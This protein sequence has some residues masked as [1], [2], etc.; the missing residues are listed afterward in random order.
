[1][2]HEFEKHIQLQLTICDQLEQIADTLPHNL[3]NQA[4]LNIARSV[5]TTIKNA[6]KFEEDKLFP[7]LLEN[8]PSNQTC[9]SLE[10]LCSEHWEDEI[11]A[12][13]VQDALINFVTTP[14]EA[15]PEALGY[16]LRGFF[17]GVRRHIA[18]EREQILPIVKSTQEQIGKLQ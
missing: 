6:H 13:D 14:D 4:C 1:M 16:M 10:R 7:F 18:F 2:Q 15:N 17:E 3:D 11:Y 9:E 5:Y 12:Y 8:T